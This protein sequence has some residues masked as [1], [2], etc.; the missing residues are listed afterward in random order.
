[1]NE[2]VLNFD[3]VHRFYGDFKAL[4]GVSLRVKTGEIFG[5][6]GPNGSGK[7]TSIK[8]LL[9]LIK[10]SS[11]SVSVL[12]EDSY[13]DDD[14]AMDTRKNIGSMLEFDGLYEQITGLQ[15]LVFWAELYG[16]ESQKAKSR[17]KQ[18]ISSVKLSKWADVTVAKYSF[19]MRKRLAL[20]R[21]LVADPDV[22]I[23][24]EP[25]VGVDPESR[26]LIRNMIKDLAAQ[27][28]TIFFSSHD[29]EEVQKVCSHIAILKNGEIL[30]N[31]ALDDVITRL[32]KSKR[33]LRLKSSKN[34][35]DL[36]LKLQKM[37]YDA[38]VEGPLISFYPEDNFDISLLKG[39]ILDTWTVSSSLEEI[40][41]N[42]VADEEV[43]T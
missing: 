20:A 18:I 25:T 6:L 26:Y 34:A 14:K 32:G 36:S 9:G 15:N 41:L 33:F 23:L 24:D 19:G 5:Y 12:G 4:K 11:G 8:L 42:T 27:G 21:A 28:K 1:M 43:K 31:G 16:L 10:P 3:D 30:F 22:I 17:A 35:E 39:E 37:G 29:L 40:Y 13:A 2:I 7:T 38:K